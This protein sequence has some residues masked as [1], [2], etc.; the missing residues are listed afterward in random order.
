MI[1]ISVGGRGKTK[2]V[3][4]LTLQNTGHARTTCVGLLLSIGAVV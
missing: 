1:P 3:L 2:A 4:L